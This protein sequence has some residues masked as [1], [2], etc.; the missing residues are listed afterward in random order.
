M[1]ENVY[2]VA[3]HESG[4]AQ[5]LSGS[6][7]HELQFPKDQLPQ[8]DAF[9]SMHAYTDRYTTIPHP[10][11]RHSVADRRPGLVC[12]SDGSLTICL[13]ADLPVPSCRANWILT[14]PGQPFSL[15]VRAYEPK[16]AIKELSWPGPT[17]REPG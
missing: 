2:V 9:W 4:L 14:L 16:G 3:L 7:R 5:R 11:A 15:L 8:S 13:Q 17:I 12:C 6:T 10:A 1:D